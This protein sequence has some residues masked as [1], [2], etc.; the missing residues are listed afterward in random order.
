MNHQNIQWR[1]SAY[2]RR[3]LSVAALALLLGLALGYPQVLAF[4]AVGLAPF[5]LAH[6]RPLPESLEVTVTPSAPRCFE[7]EPIEVA[8]QVRTAAPVDQLRLRLLPGAAVEVRDAPAETVALQG[9]FAELQCTVHIDRWGKRRIGSVQVD[10]LGR[11][12]LACAETVSVGAGSIAVFPQ[13]APMARLMSPAGRTDRSGDH[14]ARVPGPGVEFSGIRPF[15]LG[16]SPR[17]INW[18]VSTRRGRL[19][20]T[21]AAAERAVDVVVVVD[22]FGDVGPAGR[23]T[24]DLT[25]RGATGVVRH[26]LNS[27][28]RVG[29]VAIGGWL[30]WI[31]AD[32]GER[33]F[34]RVAETILDV[35]GH[36]SYVAPDL[37]RIPCT[38]LPPGAVVVYFSPLLDPRGIAVAQ[39]LRGRGHPLT[40]VDVLTTEPQVHPRRPADQLAL[41]LWRLDRAAMRHRLAAVGAGVVEWDGVQSLDALLQPG[42]RRPVLERA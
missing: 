3:M 22:A 39:D 5:V 13:P 31:G 2:A 26:F 24:L 11:G 33:Q 12:R 34:Y 23:S 38:A 25:V 30:R 16:D 14:V 32:I 41:R 6:F 19:H 8:I 35:M 18:P 10:L 29:L 27:H 17:R 37:D 4:A 36:Q 15:T 42:F 28:D 7:G 21:E 40:V 20:V 1:T 9:A